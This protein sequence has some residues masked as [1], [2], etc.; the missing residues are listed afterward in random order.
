MKTIERWGLPELVSQACGGHHTPE[1]FSESLYSDVISMI[2]VSDFFVNT[3]NYGESYSYGGFVLSP[4]ALNL[5][6][7]KPRMLTNYLKKLKEK[8]MTA[9]EFLKIEQEAVS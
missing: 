7:L 8:L 2:H 4:Y 1:S 6:G 3:I 9:D 5:L